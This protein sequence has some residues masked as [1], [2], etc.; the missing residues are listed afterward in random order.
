MK[1]SKNIK[2]WRRR[3]SNP[4]PQPSSIGHYVCSLSVFT[5]NLR[6]DPQVKGVCELKPG[7]FIVPIPDATMVFRTILV[8]TRPVKDPRI[9]SPDGS[10][11]NYAARAKCLLLLALIKFSRCFTSYP[12]SST[13]NRNRPKPRRNLCAPENWKWSDSSSYVVDDIFIFVSL[14]ICGK[15]WK[16]KLT[17]SNHVTYTTWTSSL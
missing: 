12:N 14:R 5:Q 8:F 17:K 6:W 4:R 13:R 10:S 3:E 16:A 1:R 9:G 2:W 15:K 11:V 7:S